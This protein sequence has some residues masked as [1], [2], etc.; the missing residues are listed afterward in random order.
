MGHNEDGSASV[1]LAV[2]TGAATVE[3]PGISVHSAR[4]G[5]VVVT[6]PPQE[7]WEEALRWLTPT[8][9]ERIEAPAFY[10][11][12]QDHLTRRFLAERCRGTPPPVAD[13]RPSVSQSGAP[14]DGR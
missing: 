1:V 11:F 12:L 3:L 7:A 5:W 9:R 10:R 8:Q 13:L 6:V 14:S 2:K 4:P